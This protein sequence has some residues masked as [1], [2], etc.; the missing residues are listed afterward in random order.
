MVSIL[1]TGGCGFIGSH[2]CKNLNADGF[3]V[4]ILD[5]LS[6][7]IRETAKYG[8]LV[9]GSF[10]N[11]SLL[12]K[13]F[14]EQEI[15]SVFHFAGSSLVHESMSNPGIYYQNNVTNLVC[16]LDKM[17]SYNVK[18]LIFSSS[19]AVY[20]I[21]AY[22]PMDESHP[23]EPI[24][25]YGRTKLFCEKIISDFCDAHE[26]NAISLRYFNAVGCDP[27]GELGE[28]HNPE[29]HL[30]PS[31]LKATLQGENV[32]VFGSDHDTD[33]GTCVRDYVHVEDLC[34]AHTLAMKLLSEEK[35]TGYD[36]FNLGMGRGFSVD[37]IINICQFIV[38][39]DCYKIRK[40]NFP[41]RVGDPARLIANSERANK[42][43][44]WSPKYSIESAVTHAWNWLR[45]SGTN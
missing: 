4:I 2:M 1:V 6:T 39:R 17:V 32:K 31:V 30:V 3:N 38:A 5:D 37:E 42:T 20:G 28:R 36:A 26:L 23:L 43:L 12:E 27:G 10:G 7:G 8:K 14:S 19:A 21:P 13:I 18:N 35:V 41:R 15:S 9:V 16:L 25:V 29:T 40:Q 24:N 33:D 45:Q 22:L 34:L 44:G 11:A